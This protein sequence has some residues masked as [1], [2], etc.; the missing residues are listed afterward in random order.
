MSQSNSSKTLSVGIASAGAVAAAI[1]APTNH[2]A[3]DVMRQVSRDV[4]M[5]SILDEAESLAGADREA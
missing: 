1:K 4:A 2:N 3:A 5:P